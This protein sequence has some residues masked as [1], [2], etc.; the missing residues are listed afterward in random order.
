MWIFFKDYYQNYSVAQTSPDVN[1]D[2]G[3]D[4]ESYDNDYGRRKRQ[5]YNDEDYYQ[6]WADSMNFLDYW[7]S[8]SKVLKELDAFGLLSRDDNWV[9]DYEMRGNESHPY[10]CSSVLEGSV[11]NVSNVE[12]TTHGPVDQGESS[13]DNTVA[14]ASTQGIVEGASTL[15]T[16]EEITTP[17][18]VEEISTL[19]TTVVVNNL[20][21]T[22]EVSVHV[23]VVTVTSV[24]MDKVS[25]DGTVNNV[26]AAT[27]QTPEDSSTTKPSGSSEESSEVTPSLSNPNAITMIPDMA[28]DKDKDKGQPSSN[29]PDKTTQPYAPTSKTQGYDDK[30]VLVADEA[31]KEFIPEV[32]L[33][34]KTWFKPNEKVEVAELGALRN[35]SSA[36]NDLPLKTRIAM[37]HD[38]DDMLIK[39]SWAGYA[40]GTR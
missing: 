5:L 4:G 6:K 11:N 31:D 28:S 36:L 3:A 7:Q 33:S 29:K 32:D 23:E 24:T 17:G 30:T 22:E 38:L 16:T 35:I 15:G 9:F 37:G 40:C 39:C 13:T 26:I 25:S 20:A 1:N 27:V 18:T 12:V 14:D 2:Y 19:D 10:I 34:N 21:T 8:L